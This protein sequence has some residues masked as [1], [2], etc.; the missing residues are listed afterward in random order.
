MHQGDLSRIREYLYVEQLLFPLSRRLTDVTDGYAPNLAAS[1]L[2]LI[3]FAISSLGFVVQSFLYKRWLAFSIA[4]AVGAT[5]E[6]IGYVSRLLLHNDPFS[7]IG[8]KLSVVLLTFAPAFLSASIYLILKQVCLAFSPGL[9]RLRPALYTYVF[10][11]CDVMSILLQCVGGAISAIAKKKTLLDVGVNIMIAGLV[12]QVFTLLV[13]AVLAGEYFLRVRKNPGALL[14]GSEMLKR[15]T[16]F[17]CFL[18][19]A[20]V[21]YV[22]IFVRCCYRVAE[23]SGGWGNP[24]MRKEEEFIVLES[25]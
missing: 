15:S 21:S 4:L 19:A 17:K 18:I 20:T 13:F 24:I 10:I 9:S 14:P 8:F 11:S 25:V 23:L 6:A 12:F 22:C 2:F 5:A 3:I 16:L 1:L 7:D